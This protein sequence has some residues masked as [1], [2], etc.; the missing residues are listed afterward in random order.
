KIIHI[1]SHITS[2]I[3]DPKPFVCLN[4]DQNHKEDRLSSI[5]T[6]Q[7]KYRKP[8]EAEDNTKGDVRN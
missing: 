6:A 5:V 1:Y 8:E 7:K 3:I 2:Y 4:I